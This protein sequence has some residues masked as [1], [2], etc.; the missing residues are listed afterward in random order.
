MNKL[1]LKRILRLIFG[2]FLFSLGTVLIM[3]ADLGYGPWE[4]FQSGL[5]NVLP[6]TIGQAT[7]LVSIIIVLLD[8]FLKEKIGIGTLLNMLL[9]GFFM[10]W[11]LFSSL[12]PLATTIIMK[13]V[14]LISGLFTIAF[15]SYFYI[16]SGFGAGPRD[17]LMVSIRR[18]TGLPVGVSRGILEF[19]AA[20]GGYFLG[21]PLGLGTIVTAF[22]VG[23]CIQI[24]F[25][26]FS[27]ETTQIEHEDLAETF[28]FCFT[29]KN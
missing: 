13:I 16:G 22:G 18:Y 4:V 8:L 3:Q 14:L 19:S 29:T 10:D 7:I 1:K 26:L 23:I 24:V 25:H 6:L 2:L 28:N 20:M 27:F 15:G 21:G 9:I 17:S 5:T 11:I 12:I